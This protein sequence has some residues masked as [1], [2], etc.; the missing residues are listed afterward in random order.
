MQIKDATFLVTG[1]GSGLG[2]ATVRELVAG[3]RQLP[4]RRRQR[5]RPAAR[6]PRS[7]ASQARF[8]KT[9]VT[10]EASVQAA[11]DEAVRAFGSLRG[12]VNC[13]GIGIASARARQGRPARPGDVCPR[14]D[15]DQPDRH[16]QRDP[17]GGRGHRRDPAAG[18]RRA[19]RDRQHGQRRRLR[20]PDRPGRL[21][22]LEGGRGRH[23]AADRPRVGPLRHSRA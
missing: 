10:D 17:A 7:S 14:R 2:A 19:G 6:W 20:R 16:V 5:G 18:R 15:P 11:V 22:G 4:D 23:D 21:L 9:D 13:A 8:V 12:A 1:G 3:R